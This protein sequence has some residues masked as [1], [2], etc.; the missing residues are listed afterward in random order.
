MCRKWKKLMDRWEKAHYFSK[1]EWFGEL[2]WVGNKTG[3]WRI[4]TAGQ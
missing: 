2:K 1:M 4:E 3:I